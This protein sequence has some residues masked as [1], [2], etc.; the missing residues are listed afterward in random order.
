M[1]SACLVCPLQE[2]VFFSILCKNYS[3]FMYLHR[4]GH[5]SCVSLTEH[6]SVSTTKLFNCWLTLYR[7]VLSNSTI[8]SLHKWCIENI[9]HEHKRLPTFHILKRTSVSKCWSVGW[10]NVSPCPLQNAL[11]PA[12]MR[13]K[14]QTVKKTTGSFD[15]EKLLKYLEKEAIEYKD[16]DDIVPFTGERK[17]VY[18]STLIHH[19]A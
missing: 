8:C 16:R 6:L 14:D 5:Q 12:G 11:L 10:Y 17:G 15:R 13:Q 1:W 7:H 19:K 9:K 3:K 4:Y 18:C 2:F